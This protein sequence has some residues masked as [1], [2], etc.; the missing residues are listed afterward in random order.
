MPFYGLLLVLILAPLPFGSN[1]PWSWS[2]LSLLIGLLT[3][4]WCISYL[5]K[6]KK[7]QI[8]LA[9]I[10]VPLLLFISTILWAFIQ[11]STLIPES[12]GHPLWQITAQTLEIEIPAKISLAPEQ[13]TTAAMRLMSYGLVFIL[14]MYYCQKSENAKKLFNWLAV[15]GFC[16]AVYG[17]F[18][19]LG[20]FNKIL[21][22]DKWTYQNDVTSTIVNRNS[23]A[24]YA[25]LS[26]LCL[27]P[28][29]LR[30]FKSSATYGLN[31]N[32]G[33]QLFIETLITRAWQPTLMFFIVGTALF[34]SHSRGGFLS[35]SLAIICLFSLLSFSKKLQ[36]R[37]LTFAAVAVI[38]MAV[39]L[40]SISS[41]KLMQRMGQISIEKSERLKV[42]S[43]TLNGIAN[44][45]YLGYGYG[46]YESSFRLYRTKEIRSNYDKAHNTY[47]EN[48]FE[49][50]IPAASALFISIFLIALRCLTGIWNRQRNWVY[51]AIG[52]SSTI[53][54]AAHSLVDFSL[55]I[56]AVAVTYA[57]MLG[58][59]YA[60]AFSSKHSG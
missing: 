8:H 49:L 59:G 48:I 41:E 31:S 21:W 19:Y 27:I 11:T 33:K 53:L 16:Y 15:A 34:L 39:T 3:I 52:F 57:A 1:R 38:S 50:G 36:N 5:L 43:A 13:S 23:Y 29:I 60:Q 18:I 47:L 2:L 55:Q 40:F 26:L 22:F 32:Y 10:K 20:D 24:T 30:Q 12:W 46:S 4:S 6:E 54:V 9:R 17:L 7:M 44:N 51:P 37:A 58:A 45:P 42:Y 35:T 56:P 25:G 28:N 14:A